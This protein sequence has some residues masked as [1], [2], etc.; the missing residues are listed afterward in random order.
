MMAS[1]IL[2]SIGPT[3]ISILKGP[4]NRSVTFSIASAQ[5]QNMSQFSGHNDTTP[6]V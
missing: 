1:D 2:M 4:S 6:N 5:N 3:T